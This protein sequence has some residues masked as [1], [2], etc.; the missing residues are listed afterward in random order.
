MCGI[1]GCGPQAG[2][3]HHDHGHDHHHDHEHHPA[4]R[5][6][7]ILHTLEQPVFAKNDAV[8]ARNRAW[9]QGREILVLNL[10]SAPSAGKTTL[11]ERTILA[12][13]R[14]GMRGWP[15]RRRRRGPKP[16]RDRAGG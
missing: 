2:A 15:G 13:W 12:H 1:C 5:P 3:E 10:V 9:F 7:T 8:A 16:S 6:K 11:L 14:S 4:G